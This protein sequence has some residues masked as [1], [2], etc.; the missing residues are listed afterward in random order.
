MRIRQSSAAPLRPNPNRRTAT[1]PS[2]P[3]RT[4]GLRGAPRTRRRCCLANRSTWRFGCAV[5]QRPQ[6]SRRYRLIPDCHANC[7]PRR[8]PTAG[9]HCSFDTTFD[10]GMAFR[11]AKMFFLHLASCTMRERNV[12][13]KSFLC[14]S[15]KI[16]STERKII[17]HCARSRPPKCPVQQG[18]CS[19]CCGTISAQAA[20]FSGVDVFLESANLATSTAERVGFKKRS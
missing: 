14:S 16:I 15:G 12:A 4:A 8:L 3:E 9:Y 1:A 19:V 2:A 6:Q 20:P 11:L 18:L 13:V 5:Q 17:F 7:R 10:T